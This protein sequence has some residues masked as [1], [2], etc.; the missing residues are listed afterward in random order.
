MNN[1]SPPAAP[2]PSSDSQDPAGDTAAARARIQT[3]LTPAQKRAQS[4]TKWKY[5]FVN[6]MMA[7]LD[8]LIYAE[9]CIVYYME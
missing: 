6:S 5:E 1:D 7:S 8:T 9:L 4:Q 2:E 3:E